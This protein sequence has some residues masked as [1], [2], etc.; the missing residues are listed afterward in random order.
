MKTTPMDHQ[1]EAERRLLAAP[2]I[3]A[4]AA[5]QGTGKT[6]MLMND[7][8]RQFEQGRINGLLVIA[9]KGVHVN[10]VRREIPLHMSVPTRTAFWMSGAPKRHEKLV[11]GVFQAGEDELAV[12]AMN[13]DAVNTKGGLECARRF[14]KQFRAMMVVDESHRIK[15]PRA[16]RT[17]RTV[18]LG[19]LAVSRRISSGT[20]VADRPTDLFSQYDFLRPGLLGTTSYR[21]FVAEYTDLLPPYHPLVQ[22]IIRKSRGRGSPQVP[23]TD[24]DGH[25]VYRNLEKL[26]G[27]MAPHTYRV[28]KDECMDLPPKIYQTHYF[29]LSSAQQ[30]LYDSVKTNLRHERDDGAVDVFSAMTAINKLRQITSGFII[31]DGTPAHL[32]E[33]Q[34]TP[35]LAAL[36]E[37]LEDMEGP[38]IVWASFREELTMVARELREHGV[39]EY[40]GGSKDHDGA[41]DAFQEGRVRILV[42]NPASGGEGL[43]LT[44]ARNVI[45][46]SCS[47][48]RRERVQSEDRSHRKGTRHPVLYVDLAARDT[49]DEDIAEALQNKEAVAEEIVGRL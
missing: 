47:F 3:Y 44:A 1:V 7:A 18:T 10:W 38:V 30:R 17:K 16:K 24:E 21:S 42:A 5:E 36:K 9:P 43:T 22:D 2:D 8:E 41:V 39:A 13:V 19:E 32:D 20:L 15:N 35:R 14:L 31:Q 45:Y 29:D 25:P 11:E 49:V 33:D 28:T 37:V 27:L 12:L 34:A 26:S 23:R 40:H 46:Y 48:S 4:L 6:W